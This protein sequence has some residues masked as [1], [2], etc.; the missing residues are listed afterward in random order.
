MRDRVI[1]RP[2][3]K[4][5]GGKT[6]L[7]DELTRH[8]P[9]YFIN[10]HEPFVGGGALF[11]K[12]YRE[13][14]IRHAIISDLNAELIDTYIAI[15]DHVEEVMDL[16][17]NFPHH[18]DFYYHLRSQNPLD[19]DLVQR[20][21]RMIYL[22]KTGYNGLYRVNSQGQFNVPF[23]RYKSP[24]ICDKDNL[25]AVSQ[26]LQRIEILCAP[27]ETI[28]ER[29]K[30]GDLVYF[31][32]PY[33]PLSH[34]SNFTFYHANGFSSED[35]KRLRDV[36]IQLTQKKINVMVS[37]SNAGI[38]RNLYASSHFFFDEVKAIRAINCNGNRRGKLIELLITNYPLEKRAQLRLVEKRAA[39]STNR[40][41]ASV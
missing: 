5:A 9:I 4:W 21:A 2:F 15:R 1:P 25:Y 36:C 40:T 14:R 37:N 8:M 13:G 16:L 23:G 3:L 33:A 20:A 35:Q 34:T 28:L 30:A 26:A 38:I 41:M 39:F 19:L 32:P 10:Y 24:Q 17:D 11:F 22:N 7:V 29:A 12:L 18:E 27:F 6:Q 31:D